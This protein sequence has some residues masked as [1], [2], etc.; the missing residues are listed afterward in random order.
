MKV[1]Q[2]AVP[3]ASLLHR[4]VAQDGAYTDCFQVV[5]AKSATHSEFVQ[6]FYTT[7]LF[8]LERCVLALALRRRISDEEVSALADDRSNRFAVWHVEAR[9]ENQMLLA[10]NSGHTKSFLALEA[11]ETGSVRLI[12]GSA[13]VTKGKQKLSRLVR[14]T[15]WLHRLY[16]IGLLKAAALRLQRG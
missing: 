9:S 10:D 13:V 5:I 8:R 6:A 4:Y 1:E 3:Q 14:A 15:I 12:F 2:I 16:S 7:W 11:L